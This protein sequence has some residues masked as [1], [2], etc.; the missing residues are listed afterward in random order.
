MASFNQYRRVVTVPNG[1]P[2]TWHG[3]TEGL[4][5]SGLLEPG[6]LG[7]VYPA[8]GDQ[9]QLVRMDSGATASTPTGIP[10]AGQVAFWKD[11]NNYLVTNDSRQADAASFPAGAA[12]RDA[13]NSVAGV[14]EMAVVGGE[15]F[16]VHQKGSSNVK[17]STSPNPGDQ[18]SA[19]TGTNADCTSTAAGTAVPSQLVGVVTSATKTGGLIPAELVVE[20]VD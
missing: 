8:L 18:L 6:E 17:T 16:F 20:F 9:F 3:N 5:G 2:Y 11:R 1:N 10:A 14:V 15:Y 19:G 7:G 4:N 12:T 13:R